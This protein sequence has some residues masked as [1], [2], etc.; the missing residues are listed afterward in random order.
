MKRVLIALLL[1]VAPLLSAVDYAA[2][3]MWV[4]RENAAPTA[5]KPADVF[6]LAP[7]V[8]M[9]AEK[10]MDV[11]SMVQRFVF[12][13]AVV[14]QHDIY[15]DKA[16]F[17]APYYRQKSFVH[18][19]DKKAHETAYEDVRAAFLYYLEHDNG[20]RPFIL[21]GF[22]QGSEHALHLIQDVLSNQ[23][24][25]ARMVAAYLIGWCV[26]EKSVEGYPQLRPAAGETDT[27]VFITWN[28][29]KPEVR[30]SLLVPF[31]T[32]AF[33]INPLNWRTDGTPAPSEANKG[34]HGRSFMAPPDIHPGY[35][36]AIINTERG[37]LN[38]V[39]PPTVTDP[40]TLNP[41]F[42]DKIYHPH[43]P[44]LYYE[45]LRENV[46]KRIEA[47]EQRRTMP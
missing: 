18:Y 33:V 47:F 17:F 45:N 9:S 5:D 3:D 35:C 21:A 20:G 15:A 23:Q 14:S 8:C 30:H 16:R 12:R 29:E 13:N 2:A 43:E 24:L 28:S 46:R 41:I 44:Y 39:F 11:H 32:R 40:T 22:S 7:T 37:T 10:N 38:P 25:A 42:G 26:T 4:Y 34:G 27:G 6:F 36:G 1:L 31:G 19:V